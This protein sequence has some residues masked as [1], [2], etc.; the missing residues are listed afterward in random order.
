MR[1]YRVCKR[2]HA[3]TAFSGTGARYYSGRWHHAG[4]AVIY[5]SGS[6]SLMMVEALVHF[7]HDL[8]PTRYVVFDIDIPD[9][10]KLQHVAVADLQK[11]WRQWP[12]P[13]G[14]RDLGTGWAEAAKTV[15]LVV[16]SAIV[17]EEQNVILNPAHPDFVKIQ[18]G[19]MRAFRFDKRLLG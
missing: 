1:T 15:G 6:L 18:I 10:L 3:K 5:T 7:D 8:A 4:T 19:S 16:P 12:Q 14:L 13:R 17:P 11:N 9:H 2:Q